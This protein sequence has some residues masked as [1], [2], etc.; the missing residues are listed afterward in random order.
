[1][2]VGGSGEMGGGG[3]EQKK[4]TVAVVDL[5]TKVRTGEGAQWSFQVGEEKG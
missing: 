2:G 5:R 3:G 1:V 4:R